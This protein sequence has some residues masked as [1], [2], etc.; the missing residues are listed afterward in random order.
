MILIFL[1]HLANG[2][3]RSKM[4]FVELND[5]THKIIIC[6]VFECRQQ[7]RAYATRTSFL[8]IFCSDL[9]QA[10]PPLSALTSHFC[11]FLLAE[12]VWYTLSIFSG[13]RPQARMM[14]HF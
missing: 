3:M 2:T 14:D 11:T 4:T 6:H 12:Q 8:Y 5:G 9:V 7:H 13:S 1:L 10:D